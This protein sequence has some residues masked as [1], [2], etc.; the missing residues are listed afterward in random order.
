MI[1]FA[2][3]KLNGSDDI[4]SSLLEHKSTT[5]RPINIQ[6]INNKPTNQHPNNQQQTDQ[7]TS[8]QSTTNRPIN[9]Q[10]INN[11]PTIQQSTFNHFHRTPG[12][13]CLSSSNETPPAPDA[14]IL[15]S[16]SLPFSFISLLLPW[17]PSVIYSSNNLINYLIMYLN[18]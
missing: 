9:I 6:T 13:S 11:Q 4:S 1:I 7:S 3:L 12:L 8:K 5:T 16:L 18:V 2:H 14:R 15:S 10:T 17:L